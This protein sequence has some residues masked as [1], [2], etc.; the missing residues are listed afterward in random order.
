MGKGNWTPRMDTS[1][2]LNN[3]EAAATKPTF[4]RRFAAK[5][6]KFINSVNVNDVKR[7]FV[8]VVAI[9]SVLHVAL[10]YGVNFTW[11][12]GPSMIPTISGDLPGE[13]V[14]I[15]C[16]SYKIQKKTYKVGD[17]VISEPPND[18]DKM[19]CKRIAAIE[20]DEVIVMSRNANHR[21]SAFAKLPEGIVVPPGHVWL[22][23]DNCNNSTDSRTYGP[24]PIALIQGKVCYKA[25]LAPIPVI[26][27]ESKIW[28]SDA[29]IV[30]RGGKELREESRT[31]TQALTL[32]KDRDASQT[33]NGS[34][35]NG[36]VVDIQSTVEQNS[37]KDKLS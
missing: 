37:P 23:G 30:R 33:E 32:T 11:C 36:Q 6:F 21:V 31:L 17:V 27:I 7:G 12:I 29:I 10:T 2:P 1:I 20:G 26:A 22:A 18:T 19:V 3:T 4:G 5:V 14:F 15:D 9:Q 13:M 35:S 8:F 16:F 25:V 34:R 24:V 28:P